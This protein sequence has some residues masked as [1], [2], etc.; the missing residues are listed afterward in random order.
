MAGR[1]ETRKNADCTAFFDW[2][3]GSGGGRWPRRLGPSGHPPI[4]KTSL[5]LP[6]GI[7]SGRAV[8]SR[9]NRRSGHHSDWR[10]GRVRL[11]GRGRPGLPDGGPSDDAF[12]RNGLHGRLA[13]SLHGRATGLSVLRLRIDGG[14]ERREVGIPVPARCTARKDAQKRRDGGNRPEHDGETLANSGEAFQSPFRR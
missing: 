5:G 7:P 2:S 14:H 11:K 8:L 10:S 9:Q 1:S 3:G 6:G 13:D 4:T 12:G